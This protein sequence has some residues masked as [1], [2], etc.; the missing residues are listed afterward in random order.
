MLAQAREWELVHEPLVDNDISAFNGKHRPAFTELMGM[1]GRREV[2]AVLILAHR[3]AG[4][5]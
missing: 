4:A 3:P 5:A 1:I 2:D